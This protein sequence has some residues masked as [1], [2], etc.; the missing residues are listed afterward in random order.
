MKLHSSLILSL[1]SLRSGKHLAGNSDMDDIVKQ[2]M[3][4]WPNR[5]RRSAANSLAA[6]PFAGSGALPPDYSDTRSSWM[7]LLNKRWPNGRMCRRST[8]GWRWTAAGNG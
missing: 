5:A 1:T 4:Q 3:A 2:A 6:G 7:T 8:A